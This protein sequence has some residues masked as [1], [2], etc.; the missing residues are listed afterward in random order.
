M[1]NNKK[2]IAAAALAAVCLSGCAVN[3]VGNRAPS[4]Y[5]TTSSNTSSE[6]SAAYEA[7][8]SKDSDI[9]YP[10]IVYVPDENDTSSIPDASESNP[11]IVYPDIAYSE[12]R[13]GSGSTS[14][15]VS[16]SGS[17]SVSVSGSVSD[18]KAICGLKSKVETSVDACIVNTLTDHN[19][20]DVAYDYGKNYDAFV[21]ACD[22]SLVF[23]ADFYAESFPL[24]AMQYHNDKKLLLRKICKRFRLQAPAEDDNDGSPGC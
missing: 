5:L 9:E 12:N 3:S 2:I 10:G 13:N 18:I 24:L 22:W 20:Y 21:S 7:S 11:G 6:E 17:A 15:P 1:K 4:T 23:D 14:V 16:G 8:G 19:P